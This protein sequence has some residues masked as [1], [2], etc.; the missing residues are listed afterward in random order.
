[1]N[2]YPEL[3]PRDLKIIAEVC[4]GSTNKEIGERLNLSENTVKNLL[5]VIYDILDVRDRLQLCKVYRENYLTK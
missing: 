2:Q 3:S 1:M 4:K 5:T